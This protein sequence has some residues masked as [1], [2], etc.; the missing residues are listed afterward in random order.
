[1]VLMSTMKNVPRAMVMTFC[2]SPYPNIST[3]SGM[4]ASL[5]MG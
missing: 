2:S 1:M 4:R 5:G 3:M